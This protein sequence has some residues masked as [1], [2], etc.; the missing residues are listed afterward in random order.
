MVVVVV[1][2]KK[3]NG[4]GVFRGRTGRGDGVYGRYERSGCLVSRG[5]DLPEDLC[6]PV[7]NSLGLLGR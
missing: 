7:E 2:G 6:D 1:V 5:G 3:G 4:D